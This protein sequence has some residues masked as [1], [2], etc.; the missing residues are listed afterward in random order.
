M[1]FHRG[2]ETDQQEEMKFVRKLAY[3]IVGFFWLL[4]QSW[5]VLV[6]AV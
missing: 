5:E 4:E 6:W 1:V 2:L 3:N